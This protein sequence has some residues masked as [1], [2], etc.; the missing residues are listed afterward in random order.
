VVKTLLISFG[1]QVHVCC[2]FGRLQVSVVCSLLLWG[3]GFR[4]RGLFLVYKKRGVVV[5]LCGFY[6]LLR[7]NMKPSGVVLTY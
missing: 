6:F 3:G 7:Y 1:L 2:S 4:G 5:W